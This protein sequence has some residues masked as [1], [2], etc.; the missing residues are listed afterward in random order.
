[1]RM[2]G[3]TSTNRVAYLHVTKL[4]GALGIIDGR[5]GRVLLREERAVQRRAQARPASIFKS[6]SLRGRSTLLSP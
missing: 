3:P 5:L 1:M 6:S 2:S 4:G